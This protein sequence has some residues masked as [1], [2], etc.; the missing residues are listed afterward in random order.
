[1]NLIQFYSKDCAELTLSLNASLCL[2]LALLYLLVQFLPV[3][4]QLNHNLILVVLYVVSD[5]LWLTHVFD[6]DTD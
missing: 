6:F 4:L 3:F 2:I 1:M 5:Q